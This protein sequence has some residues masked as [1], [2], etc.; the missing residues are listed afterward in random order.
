[1]DDGFGDGRAQFGH[2]FR[3]PLR[4]ATAV[5]RK[6]CDA[7]AFH[8]ANDLDRSLALSIQVVNETAIVQLSQI[9]RIPHDQRV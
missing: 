3:K 1:L 5:K 6:I 9:M 7:G 4:D 8:A 2:P